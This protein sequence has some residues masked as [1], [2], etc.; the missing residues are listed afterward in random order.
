MGLPHPRGAVCDFHVVTVCLLATPLPPLLFPDEPTLVLP[1]PTGKSD[2]S[3]RRHFPQPWAGQ[4]CSQGRLQ[5]HF[6]P[7]GVGLFLVWAS[8]RHLAPELGAALWYVWTYH[9]ESPG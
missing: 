5:V 8:S 7:L 2:F 1:D 4:R 9:L 3:L 6:R